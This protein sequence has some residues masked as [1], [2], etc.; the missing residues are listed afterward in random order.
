VSDLGNLFCSH[1]WLQPFPKIYENTA[2]QKKR[3]SKKIKKNQKK[4]ETKII[5]YQDY[6]ESFKLKIIYN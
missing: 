4:S 1:I 2:W 5:M 6:F 3:K